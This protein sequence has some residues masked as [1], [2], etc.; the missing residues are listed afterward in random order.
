MEY[1]IKAYYREG[2]KPQALRQAGKLPGVMYNRSLNRKVYVDLSEF[3]KVFRQA[4][5]H[6]V[7]VLELPMGRCPPW[8]AR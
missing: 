8:C 2:E 1:R 4:S 5:I 3:D 7:I 6:H